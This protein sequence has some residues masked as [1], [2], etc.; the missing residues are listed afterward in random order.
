[1][2]GAPSA[3]PR[4]RYCRPPGRGLR[5]GNLGNCHSAL[6]DFIAIDLHT[7]ALALHRDTG[8][9]QA[10][11][12]R[13]ATWGTAIFHTTWVTMGRPST[14]L[15]RPSAIVRDIADRQVEGPVLSYLAN[16]HLH[17]GDY[18]QA[19]DLL[20][21][22]WPSP[23][24]SATASARRSRSSPIWAGPGWRDARGDPLL[25]EQAVSVADTAATLSQRRR[26][27]RGWRRPGSSSEQSSGCPGRDSRAA[28]AAT[29][30]PSRQCG[31]WKGWPCS[32]SCRCWTRTHAGVQHHNVGHA[33]ALLALADSNVSAP[34]AASFTI[35]DSPR[36]SATQPRPR[37]PVRPSP[38]PVPLEAPRASPR[39]H[40]P[41]A[42]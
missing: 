35:T 13:W 18:G 8:N 2:S 3:G 17:L 7:Q 42:R 1:M 41:P 26:L 6:G 37:R 23:A 9:R 4:P 22:P 10:R 31:C 16:A 24:T 5:A 36:P 32:T 38:W 39:E 11:A 30:R 20:P 14:C 12:S 21:R 27:S 34:A 33:N 29:Y 25:L 40:P 19:I 28:R 15:P